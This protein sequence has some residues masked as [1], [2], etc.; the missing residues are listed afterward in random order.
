MKYFLILILFCFY[1]NGVIY[2]SNF[3]EFV[4]Q[5]FHQFSNKVTSA[6]KILRQKISSL[7][8][9]EVDS[10]ISDARKYANMKQKT[11]AAFCDFIEEEAAQM[12]NETPGYDKLRSEPT[13]LMS[14]LQLATLHGK[15]MESH[16]VT[17]Q[18]GYLLTLHRLKSPAFLN[19][20]TV[21]SLNNSTVLL[22]HGLLGS[23][24]DW[25][26]LGPEKSLPYILSNAGCDVWLINARGNYYSRGHM[27]KRVD[28]L[29]YWNFSFQE[30]GEY[31]LPAIVDYIRNTKNS[32][33]QISFIGHSLGATAF[34]I[35]LSSLPEYNNYFRI[36]VLLAPLVYM[37]NAIGPLRIITSMAKTPP[38]QLLNLLGNGEF[39][40]NRKIP[41][42]IASRYCNGHE[43][44]C[45]NPLLFLSGS[46]PE[47]DSWDKSL[48]AN[49]LYHLP[50][51]GSTKT[52]LHIA[53]LVKS[54]TFHKFNNEKELFS[55][56]NVKVPIALFSSR[57]DWIATT[58][59]V[60]RLFFS[61]VNPIDH[62]AI[63]HKK[64]S[65]TDFVWSPNANILIFEKVLYYLEN[66]LTINS[67]NT[68]EILG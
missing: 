54:G 10:V 38:E 17:S 1:Q 22:H 31:D 8:F 16:V 36:G 55:V 21:S 13:A 35:M 44:Y 25:I 45:L 42:W 24:A 53:Q 26:L 41:S 15:R 4:A 50:A 14:T 32:T 64:I 7:I 11:K 29:E 65:H 19:E 18:D 46:I 68:N 12:E 5:K 49:V 62:F 47:E 37:T 48:I 43:M 51:G 39:L 3:G 59:D 23:S 33:D 52:I 30:M 20:N 9:P 6:F 2:C 67:T 58:P 57:D 27:N 61:I 63:K 28:S 60:L 66:G 34:I 40:P 56:N